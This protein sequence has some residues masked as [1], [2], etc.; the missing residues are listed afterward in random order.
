MQRGELGDS[1]NHQSNIDGGSPIV[2]TNRKKRNFSA[3]LTMG[4][5]HYGKSLTDE[6]YI[7]NAND[8]RAFMGIH[9]LNAKTIRLMREYK[10]AFPLIPFYMNASKSRELNIGEMFCGDDIIRIDAGKPEVLAE[11]KEII[12]KFYL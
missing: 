1:E 7:P 3:S 9:V 8:E 6:E 12:D 2:V 4:S 5:K 11:C 10:E